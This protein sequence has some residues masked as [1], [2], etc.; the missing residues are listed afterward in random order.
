MYGTVSDGAGVESNATVLMELITKLEESTGTSQSTEVSIPSTNVPPAQSKFSG[1]STIAG[2]HLIGA[3]VLICLIIMTI[4][5]VLYKKK[6]RDAKRNLKE[7][8]NEA[9]HAEDQKPSKESSKGSIM[10]YQDTIVASPSDLLDT[11]PI[12]SLD[13]VNSEDKPD[14]VKTGDVEYD[15]KLNNYLAMNERPYSASTVLSPNVSNQYDTRPVHITYRNLKTESV[16]SKSSYT[17]SLAQQSTY[18]NCTAKNFINKL[19][20]SSFFGG[21][22]SGETYVSG[23]NSY[24]SGITESRLQI[25]QTSRTLAIPDHRTSSIR[26]PSLNYYMSAEGDADNHPEHIVPPPRRAVPPV[27]NSFLPLPREGT[28]G[29]EHLSKHK[30]L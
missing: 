6:K 27:T 12:S 30:N 16:A 9:L 25:P 18:S 21:S 26:S 11:A 8:N 2:Y 13:D 1:I 7:L 10:I 5:I 15:A 28:P 17:R 4:A 22:T 3:A 14:T 23:T 29:S 19:H 20:K 24:I